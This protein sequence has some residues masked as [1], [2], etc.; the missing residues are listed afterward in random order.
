[1][2][3]ITNESCGEKVCFLPYFLATVPL[4]FHRAALMPTIVTLAEEHREDHVPLFLG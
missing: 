4:R 3:L 2:P 1:M